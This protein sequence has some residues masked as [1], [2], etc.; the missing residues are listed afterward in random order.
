MRDIDVSMSKLSVIKSK[1]FI[2]VEEIK[3]NTNRL[4]F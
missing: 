4:L 1:A 3:N 2:F